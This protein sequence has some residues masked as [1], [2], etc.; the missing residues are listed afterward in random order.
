[1]I[2]WCLAAHVM[3]FGL[4]YL[5]AN[6]VSNAASYFSTTFYNRNPVEILDVG[7]QTIS[8][9]DDLQWMTAVASHDR[10][11]QFSAIDHLGTDIPAG[12]SP[13]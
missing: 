8:L 13:S 5:A 3:V 11:L 10:P 2:P 1:M 9:R 4:S 12:S 6:W 7:F